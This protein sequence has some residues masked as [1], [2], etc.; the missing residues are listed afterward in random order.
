MTNIFAVNSQFR[1]YPREQVLFSA[2]LYLFCKKID[3]KLTLWTTQVR[4]M[5]VRVKNNP[6][7]HKDFLNIYQ[8]SSKLNCHEA[9]PY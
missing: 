4:Y 3:C 6:Y 1:V 8:G 2:Y 9:S 7:T 5:R